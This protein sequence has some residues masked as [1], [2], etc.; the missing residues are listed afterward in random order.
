[1][2]GDKSPTFDERK[3]EKCYKINNNV[4]RRICLMY[5]LYYCTILR[6]SSYVSLNSED[7]NIIGL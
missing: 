2:R 6:K 7:S 3:S 4:R 5:K 1:M